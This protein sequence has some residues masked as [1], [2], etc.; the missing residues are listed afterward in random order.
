[1]LMNQKVA[2]RAVTAA[3]CVFGSMASVSAA[4]TYYADGSVQNDGGNGWG[5]Q[6]YNNNSSSGNYYAASYNMQNQ[7]KS[8]SRSSRSSRGVTPNTYSDYSGATQATQSQTSWGTQPNTYTSSDYT[9]QSSASYDQWNSSYQYQQ[10]QQPQKR[11]ILSRVFGNSDA[12]SGK[13]YASGYTGTSSLGQSG[14]ASW[15]GSDFHGGKTANGER[16]DMYS[17]TAAHRTLPFGTLVK[18]TNECN[19][20]ECVVRINNRGPYLKGRILDLSKAAATQLGM[21]SRGV[22]KVRM[23][24]LGQ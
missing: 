12:T 7:P 1:M 23:Q 17:M 2:A 4:T 22:S 21:V 16:Y 13:N 8:S 9:N 14:M 11:G 15:Y 3:V 19:G 5:S 6:Y 18:V 24:V 10:Q 20:R